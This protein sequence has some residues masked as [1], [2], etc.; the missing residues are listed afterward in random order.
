MVKASEKQ[1]HSK[2]PLRYKQNDHRTTN[3]FDKQEYIWAEFTN[4]MLH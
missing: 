1:T 4:N 3:T 2:V